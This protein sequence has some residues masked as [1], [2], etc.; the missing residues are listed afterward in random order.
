MPHAHILLVMAKDVDDR[1]PRYVDEYLSAEIPDVPGPDDNSPRAEQQRRLHQLVTS[2][3]LHDCGDWC[4]VNGKCSKRFPKPFSPFTVLPDDQYPQYKRRSP[5]REGVVVPEEARH[6]YGN[7]HLKKKGAV[8][9]LFDNRHVVPYNPYLTLKYGCH[10][11]VE[12]VGAAKCA[13]YAFKYVLKGNDRAYVRLQSQGKP[14]LGKDGLQI[15]DYDEMEHNFQARYMTAHEAV[16]RL[17]GYPI[18]GL[19]H[20]VN[21]L[22]VYKPGGRVVFEEGHE[23]EAARRASKPAKNSLTDFFELCQTDPEAQQYCY[24]QIG[25]HYTYAKSGGWKKRKQNVK[26]TL[27]RLQSVLPRDRVGYALRLLLLTRVSLR[28]LENE[29]VS[30]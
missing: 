23:E 14:K 29:V 22:Y 30:G 6:L 10:L 2:H 4:M 28:I 13:E 15:V 27:V 1:T 16:W 25:L 26:K 18:V 19:S 3:M 17:M 11:N 12:Y 5:A 21:V 8:S 20:T 9:I 24:H 7:T